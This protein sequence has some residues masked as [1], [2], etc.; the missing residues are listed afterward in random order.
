MMH[1]DH[2]KKTYSIMMDIIVYKIII[3]TGKFSMDFFMKLSK[4]IGIIKIK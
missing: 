3:K 2:N 1:I 4:W